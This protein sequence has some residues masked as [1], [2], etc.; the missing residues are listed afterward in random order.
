MSTFV[1]RVWDLGLSFLVLSAL[2]VPIERAFTART[3]PHLR[4]E[5]GLDLVYFIAQYLVFL[6]F[7]LSFN[8][9][10]QHAASLGTSIGD[11]P[12]PLQA[13]V[14]VV[15]GDVVVYWGHRLSHEIPLLWRFHR[16]HHSVTTLDWMAAHREHPLDGVFSQICLNLPMLALGVDVVA[17]APV[18]VFRGLC[19]NFVHSN[20]RLE[21]GWF[22]LF[23]GDPALHRWH[24]ARRHTRHN[25]ANLAPYLD[26]LFGTHHRPKDEDYALGLEEESPRGFVRQLIVPLLPRAADALRIG[27][28][29]A[30]RA[31]SRG[32]KSRALRHRSGSHP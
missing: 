15:L 30:P 29:A 22:G 31:G 5:I 28:P 16:V 24:H 13:V 11:W 19:A 12:L 10:L 20:A 17:L 32:P 25:Y 14:A 27:T 23:F 2:F 1:D 9:W 3:Q 4:R 8:V 21:L 18:F 26:L 6:P 7:L